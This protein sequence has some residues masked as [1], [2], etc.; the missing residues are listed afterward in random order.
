MITVRVLKLY[1]CQPVF[2]NGSGDWGSIPGR[3]IPKTQKIVFD[4]SLLNTQHYKVRIKA[5][6]SN[7][8]EKWRPLLH[9]DVAAIEKGAFGSPSTTVGQLIYIY[10]YLNSCA[11]FR[12]H[13]NIISANIILGHFIQDSHQARIGHK[14]RL[15]WCL[16]EIKP[17]AVLEQKFLCSV[18]IPFKEFLGHRAIPPIL[19]PLRRGGRWYTFHKI[20]I[21]LL[22]G[23]E[24][25]LYCRWAPF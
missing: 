8:G 18:D 21:S 25:A 19:T 20:I 1:F 4:A 2:T 23:Q 5:K 6:R 12:S 10:I 17:S 11:C 22:I 16:V 3:V 13:G 9:L 7:Q 14:M 24:I 15:T